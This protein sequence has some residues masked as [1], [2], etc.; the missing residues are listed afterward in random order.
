MGVNPNTNKI[1][2]ADMGDNDVTVIDGAKGTTSRVTVGTSPIALAVNPV[3]NK[4]YVAD[5][6]SD[7]VMVIDGSNNS[8]SSATV[9]ML[10]QAL[11][12]D[13][14]RN[15]IYVANNGSNDVTVIDG[16]YNSTSTF[17]GGNGPVSVAV[18]PITG[19]VYVAD[20]GDEATV[21]TEQAAQPTPLVTQIAPLTSNIAIT[22]S[23]TF[24]FTTSSSYAP[25][26]RRFW[27][28]STR[29]T[30]AGTVARRFWFGR[31]SQVKRSPSPLACTSS[32]PT[33]STLRRPSWMRALT[34]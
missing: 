22:P 2:V 26:R 15:K 4:I 33:R 7:D 31:P 12:I 14:A 28:S 25:R 29:S 11:A 9:G 8:A 24:T 19:N 18:N 3:T 21:L 30:I 10:P 1:Y 6:S 13:V 34:R 27:T 20:I 23:P 5:E 17:P 16:T 32:T